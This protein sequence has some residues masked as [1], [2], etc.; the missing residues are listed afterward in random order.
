MLG[1][2][3][4]REFTMKDSYSFDRDQE[5]LDIQYAKHYKSYFR[6][7]SRCALPTIVVSADSGM[8][9]GKISHEYMYLSPI[10]E[11][12]II[13]CKKCGYTA[14]RQI[15]TFK[16]TYYQEEARDLEKV[17]TP[18]CKTIEDLARFLKIETSRTA[19]AVF[20]VGTFIDDENGEEEEKLI[21][22]VIRGDMDVEENK[23]QNAVKANALRPAHT[24]EIL[25]KKMVPGYGIAYRRIT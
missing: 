19:K 9:G 7:F 17:L 11:D 2:S 6:I 21:I 25:A 4:V 3:G 8:M 20:M 23:L 5:G 1:S 16:K 15:A 22:G 24:E 13:T 10:G 12:T 18:D 14:N